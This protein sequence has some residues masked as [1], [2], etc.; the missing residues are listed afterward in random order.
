MTYNFKMCRHWFFLFCDYI[1]LPICYV[2][3]FMSTPL[4]LI[5]FVLHW[6]KSWIFFRK[7]L[8]FL[9]MRIFCQN[10]KLFSILI[11]IHSLRTN[12]GKIQCFFSK[13]SHD[14]VCSTVLVL[15]SET[16]SFKKSYLFVFCSMLNTRLAVHKQTLMV[17]YKT[18]F[19]DILYFWYLKCRLLYKRPT[20]I[21][22]AN[23]YT[24]GRLLYKRLLI[25]PTII[26]NVRLLS[27]AL[28][29]SKWTY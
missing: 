10:G 15:S 14:F 16:V 18:Q 7:N 12:M 3:S 11:K 24:K 23:Y 4:L 17:S 1:T 22:N 26:Q 28:S 20:I 9:K 2:T 5:L 25:Q 19:H 6:K 27:N 29:Y 21:Q 8:F 13:F